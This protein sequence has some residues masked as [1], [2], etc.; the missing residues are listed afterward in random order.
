M[1]ETY[2]KKSSA[3]KA[4]KTSGWKN[5]TGTKYP[6]TVPTRNDDH[7]TVVCHEQ[8]VGGGS[9]AAYTYPDRGLTADRIFGGLNGLPS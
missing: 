4:G 1:F 6:N 8:L 7:K 3:G 5:G 2:P 9:P